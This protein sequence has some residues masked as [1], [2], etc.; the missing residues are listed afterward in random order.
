MQ[1]CHRC[2]KAIAKLKNARISDHMILGKSPAEKKLMRDIMARTEQFSPQ[3]KKNNKELSAPDFT[4]DRRP[5]LLPSPTPVSSAS[6]RSL[7][8]AKKNQPKVV[9][10]DMEESQ[11]VRER[12]RKRNPSY[13]DDDLDTSE[14]DEE[15]ETVPSKKRYAVLCY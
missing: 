2:G 13:H 12:S 7:P 14:E 11:P 8:A 5:R 9:F 1:L 6:K 4:L 10:A 15:E 3:R